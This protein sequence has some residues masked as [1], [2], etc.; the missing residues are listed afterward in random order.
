M[1][2]CSSCNTTILFG[3]VTEG[4]ERY[5]NAECHGRGYLVRVANE[6]PQFVLQR[7]TDAIYRGSCPRCQGPGPVDVHNSYRVWSALLLTSWR[8]QPNISCRGC[9]VKSQLFDTIFSLALGWWGFPWGLVMTPVQ[10]VR[11]VMAMSRSTP[12]TP[13]PELY[14]AVSF[15]LAANAVQRQAV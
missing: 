10:I 1:A 14:R 8:T 13:S 4:A 2:A 11:N 15:T 3:G 5:C 9:G 7:E 6:I 12:A